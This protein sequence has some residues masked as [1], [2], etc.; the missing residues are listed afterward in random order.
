MGVNCLQR[1][2]LLRGKG[3]GCHLQKFIG[4]G[5]APSPFLK[6]LAFLCL[7]CISPL[8]LKKQKLSSDCLWFMEQLPFN[9]QGKK[10]S[11]LKSEPY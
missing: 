3:S 8:S 4:S 7:L 1:Q 6:T 2:Q 11:S 10:C 9:V 5:V